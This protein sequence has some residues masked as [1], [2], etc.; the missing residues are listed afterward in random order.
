MMAVRFL[1][2]CNTSVRR[3][4]YINVLDQTGRS[5]VQPDLEKGI[6]YDAYDGVGNRWSLGP[7]E[8]KPFFN[9]WYLSLIFSKR[10]WM[11][12]KVSFFHQRKQKLRLTA[13]LQITIIVIRPWFYYRRVEE[14]RQLLY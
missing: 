1:V 5:F 6:P 3:C 7:F 12:L 13:V 11:L 8:P 14:I 2:I 9:F 4:Y 10:E